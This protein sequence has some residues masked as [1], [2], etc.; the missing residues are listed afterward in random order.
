MVRDPQQAPQGYPQQAQPSQAPPRDTSP[1][2]LDV[3]GGKIRVVTV[4]TG[5]FHPWGIAFADANTV[6]VTERARGRG[7]GSALLDEVDAELA[8]RGVSRG[9]GVSSSAARD[10]L[11]FAGLNSTGYF[12][13]SSSRR[14]CSVNSVRCPSFS[15]VR[16]LPSWST[17]DGARP[18]RIARSFPRRRGAGGLIRFLVRAEG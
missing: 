1:Q 16:V 12:S 5:L 10:T 3:Q 14:L 13:R 18:A 6:L 15:F 7:L 11:C 9:W 17:R 8:R 4:A 2:V